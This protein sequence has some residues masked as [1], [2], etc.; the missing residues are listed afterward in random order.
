[1]AATTPRLAE[2]RRGRTP[3]VVEATTNTFIDSDNNVGR[4]VVASHRR[5]SSATRQVGSGVVG[6]PL[7][8]EQTT[9][10]PSTLPSTEPT[11]N[12]ALSSIEIGRRR[13]AGVTN[14]AA[15]RKT[16]V[17]YK[18]DKECKCSSCTLRGGSGV[19]VIKKWED[20]DAKEY[21]KKNLLND[22]DHM[23]WNDPPSKVYDDNKDLFHLYKYEN[24]SNNL[25]GLKNG[26]SSEQE[27]VDFDE[28]V[29]EHELIAFP[30]GQ[31]TSHGN[32]Y[33]DTS[34]TKKILVELAK[35]GKLEQYKHHPSRLKQ[36]NPIFEEYNDTVFAKAV[37]REKRREKETVGWK[38]KHNIKG[39]KKNNAKYDK[40]KAD[41]E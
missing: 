14:T 13:A 28:A 37:D 16:T 19:G 33:Y 27:K 29:L 1:M 21:I 38:M 30:R 35:E 11:N 7:P 10:S 12:H 2:R 18:R 22:K 23:Y 17:R 31:V 32:P 20:S 25:R 9:R 5:R 39:S 40:I 41:G 8:I 34:K 26:I 15:R 4:L 36:S 6:L 24:F 3:P